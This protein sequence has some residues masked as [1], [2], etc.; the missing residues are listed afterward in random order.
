MSQ[1]RSHTCGELRLEH[2]GQDVQLTG[3]VNRRRDLGG[4]TFI[5]LRDRYGIV[6]VVLDPQTV[7]ELHAK[8]QEIRSEFVLFVKGKVSPR[9]EGMINK[10]RVTGEIEVHA[11]ELDILSKA[12]VLP[13]TIH[14]ETDATEALKLKY[15]YLDL[16]RPHLQR[17]LLLRHKMYSVI[18]RYLDQKNFVEIETP[19]LNKSTP[20]GARDYLVPSRVH[21]GKF[22]ALPQSP[23]LFKQLLMMSGMD[24]YYQIARCFRD[25]DLRADRQPEFTQLDMEMSFATPESIFKIMEA[26]FA[27]IF[28]TVLDVTIQTPF[29]QMSY[30]EAM[31]SH[32]TDKPDLRWDMPLTQLSQVFKNTSFRVFSEALSNHGEIRGVRI[33]KGESFSRKQIDQLTLIAKGCGAKG[34]VWMKK[35]QEKTSSSIDKFLS[36]DELSTLE[37]L[38][39]LEE[40]D[41]G[42]IVADQPSVARASLEALRNECIERLEL[43]PKRPFAFT[44]VV[45]FPLFVWDDDESRFVSVHHPFTQPHPEDVSKLKNGEDLGS[46]RALAYD[47]VLNGYEIGGG[48][49]RIHQPEIQSMIFQTLKLTEEDMKHKFG[50][51]LE[52]L[53]YGTPPH[54]G[55]ALGLDRV[56]MI[57]SGTQAIRDVIAFPKTQSALDLMAESPST[58]D[59]RQ[60]D[61]LHLALKKPKA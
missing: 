32:A 47:L 19:F 58:V 45:D 18:H 60:L 61:E 54:G 20:E 16:R 27:D 40:G 15:R 56:A 9:P 44:W 13:F 3:W 14:E 26:L 21:P 57:L 49:I 46:V 10:E 38:L 6:Q 34:V 41:L 50:F 59:P 2:V 4:L 25:E 7:P 5:D 28:Q 52:A 48:S 22:W 43:K 35:S 51:F 42:L 23:Q 8:S 11:S 17:N 12:E 36:P 39:K 1:T 24:R 53:K 37:S 33:P 31:T 30:E 55:I 29:P